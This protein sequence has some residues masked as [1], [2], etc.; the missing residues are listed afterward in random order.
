MTLLKT[1]DPKDRAAAPM[2]LGAQTGA[3]PLVGGGLLC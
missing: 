1:I 2:H 3:R